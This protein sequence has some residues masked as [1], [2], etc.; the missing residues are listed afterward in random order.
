MCHKQLQIESQQCQCC[1][2]L[3]KGC[4]HANPARAEQDGV[5]E[6]I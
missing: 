3:A 5:S 1:Y 2:V 6:C 4:L